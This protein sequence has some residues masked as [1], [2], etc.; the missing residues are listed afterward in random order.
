MID[1]FTSR[2]TGNLIGA[3]NTENGYV[4]TTVKGTGFFR[5]VQSRHPDTNV[6][7]TRRYLPDW[8]QAKEMCLFASSALPG[9]RIQHWDLA[10]SQNGPVVL[11]VNVEGSLNSH[12]V[13]AQ[14]GIYDEVFRNL[15]SILP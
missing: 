9:L 11:E 6:E 8:N 2:S 13:A 4:S 14:R 15:I 3:V 12:Q 10:L 5:I 1:H 7:L